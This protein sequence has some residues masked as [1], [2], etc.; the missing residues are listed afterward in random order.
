MADAS[1]NKKSASGRQDKLRR[2]FIANVSHELRSPLTSLL[3]FIETLQADNGLDAA[4]RQRFLGIMQAEALRM[5][6]LIDDLLSL[7]RVERDE[8]IPPT[9]AIFI[10]DVIRSAVTSLANQA[11]RRGHTMVFSD[12]CK[13]KQQP[14]RIWGDTDEIIQ[15]LR[16][17]LDNAMKYGATGVPITIRLCEAGEAAD[18]DSTP[19]I[20]LDVVNKGD[21]IPAQHIPRLTERFYRVDKGRSR[22]M[23]GTGL[24]LAIVKHIITRHR[25]RLAISSEVAGE[26]VF[27]VFLPL[28]AEDDV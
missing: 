22:D 19:R 24:G 13:N 4:M 17:L 26:T 23:G 18:N 15:L 5:S 7:A 8:H 28:C 2:D 3:G 1:K 20:R 16:N 25:G 10:E 12:E 11:Q 6:R 21:G 9:T 27:S 14:P